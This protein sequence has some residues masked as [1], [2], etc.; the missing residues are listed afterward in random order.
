MSFAKKVEQ[1]FALSENQTSIR[2][3]FFGG[4]TTFMATCYLI[5]VIPGM[6]VDAGIPHEA[7]TAATIITTILATI[8]MGLFANYPVAVAPG[9]GITAFFAY[10]VCGPAGFTWQEGLGAVFVSGVIFF[11]LTVTRIRQWIINAIPYDLKLSIIVGIGAFI[12]FIGFRNAGLIVNDASTAVALGDLTKPESILAIFGLFVTGALLI[13]RVQTAMIIGIITTTLV[14]IATGVTALPQGNWIQL[15]MPDIS[16]TFFQLDLS[17]AIHHGLISIIF[18]LTMVDLFDNMGVLLGVAK[19][20]GLMREDGS[21][22]NLDRAFISDSIATMGSSIIGT[23]TA[24]SYLESAAGAAA[25]ARTGLSNL[26]VAGF[27]VLS[28]A[29]IPIIGIVPAYATAPVLILVGALMMQECMHIRF[30]RLEVTIPAFLTIIGMPLTF[31]IATG[32]GFGFISWTILHVL[33]GRA[34]RVHPLLYIL[35]IAFIINFVLR[36]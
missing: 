30:D 6:L 27:F 23:T 29:F 7:A 1:F 20:A 36:S 16:G 8:L 21:I 15:S 12:A 3:E 32:F 34:R 31:N 13:L 5:F 10:F 24:T 28:L 14:G 18:T 26:F 19:R 9:L 4:L 35:S 33:T 17:G 2:Q 11:F 22:K 25:G